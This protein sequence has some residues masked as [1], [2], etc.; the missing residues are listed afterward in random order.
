MKSKLWKPTIALETTECN[1]YL[2]N[3]A[4][5]H[6]RQVLGKSRVKMVWHNTLKRIEKDDEKTRLTHCCGYGIVSKGTG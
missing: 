4:F 6:H 1:F 3:I 5:N 2:D